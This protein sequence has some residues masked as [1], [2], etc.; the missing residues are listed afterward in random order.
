MSRRRP[1]L[2]SSEQLMG[3]LPNLQARPRGLTAL[4]IN[5]WHSEQHVASL[6]D[7][8]WDG[9]RSV[10]TEDVGLSLFMIPPPSYKSDYATSF[11]DKA[12][13]CANK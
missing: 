5:S 11:M 9:T 4:R 3:S 2:S 13:F 7:V 12:T 10:V 1:A 6:A 8:T